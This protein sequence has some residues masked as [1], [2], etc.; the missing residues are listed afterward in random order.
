VEGLI[1]NISILEEDVHFKA[2]AFA[3]MKKL[4]LL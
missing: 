2:E 3:K 1:L 4:R